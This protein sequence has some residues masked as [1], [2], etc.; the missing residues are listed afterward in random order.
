MEV[1][2]DDVTVI[3]NWKDI[4][5][6]RNDQE[7]LHICCARELAEQE[8]FSTVKGFLYGFPIPERSEVRL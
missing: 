2:F 3:Q 8:I 5:V 7:I 6:Y 4:S 1:C